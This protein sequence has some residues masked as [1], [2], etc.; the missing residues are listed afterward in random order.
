MKEEEILR[1]LYQEAR[2]TLPEFRRKLR[3]KD[4]G[5][6]IPTS[7]FSRSLSGGPDYEI[8][9]S[10]FDNEVSRDYLMKK[11]F[12][13]T[14]PELEVVLAKHGLEE[15]I[16][17][18]VETFKEDILQRQSAHVSKAINEAREQGIRDAESDA[19]YRNRNNSYAGPD[20][21]DD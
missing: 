14:N 1:Q 2:K 19:R 11:G 7:K 10:Y 6:E 13:S 8:H 18:F 17:L 21:D 20:D 16:R 3:W 15:E 9:Q 5:N 4:V 12:S